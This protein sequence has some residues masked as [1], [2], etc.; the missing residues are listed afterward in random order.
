MRIAASA[1]ATIAVG[2]G[3]LSAVG[4]TTSG[5]AASGVRNLLYEGALTG[6]VTLAQSAATNGLGTT[7]TVAAGA[8]G[9]AFAAASTKA[10]HS[11]VK[12]FT[13]QLKKGIPTG[14]PISGIQKRPKRRQINAKLRK[15][16][17]G[18]GFS[19]QE[20]IVHK[21]DSKAEIIISSDDDSS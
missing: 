13:S 1:T 14:S 6:L 11:F 9:A 8:I 20:I 2:A 21:T 10:A 12:E 16:N 3:V 15:K 4:V 18:S 17:P 19:K 7:G 5:I